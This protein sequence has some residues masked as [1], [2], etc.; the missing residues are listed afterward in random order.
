[1]SNRPFG[2]S[3]PTYH[4]YPQSD[5]E[6]QKCQ[7]YP[8]Y[9]LLLLL[10]ITF[11]LQ[12]AVFKL[13][14]I[15]RKFTEW[16]KNKLEH[17][18]VKVTLYHNMGYVVLCPKDAKVPNFSPFFELQAILRQLRWMTPKWPWTQKGQRYTMYIHST[19]G[20]HA[21]QISIHLTQRSAILELQDILRQVHQ[22][23][24]KTNWPKAPHICSTCT[25][26]WFSPHGKMMNLKVKKI[27]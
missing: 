24:L 6:L 3:V 15:L 22:M 26:F 13:L 10:S 18:N 5:L 2:K 16:P 25:S 23:N 12:P 27:I 8:K 17:Y 11:A 1:M 21:S 20:S 4:A 7:R 19:C 9:V 14:V